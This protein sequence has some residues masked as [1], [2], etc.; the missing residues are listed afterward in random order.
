[1]VGLLQSLHEE[2]TLVKQWTVRVVT[3]HADFCFVSSFSAAAL[4]EILEEDL[5]EEKSAAKTVYEHGHVENHVTFGPT[6]PRPQPLQSFFG[7]MKPKMLE[8]DL[9]TIGGF[10]G[11]AGRQEGAV[12]ASVSVDWMHEI[13]A[14]WG[15]LNA[16]PVPRPPPA[17]SDALVLKKSK[18]VSVDLPDDWDFFGDV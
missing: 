11:F 9:P 1:V 12:A 8:Q 5:L 3:A 14:V 17:S 18:S 16:P 15:A 7:G 4:P 13:D 10:P 6:I 2:Q